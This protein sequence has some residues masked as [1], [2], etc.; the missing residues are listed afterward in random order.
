[1]GQREIGGITNL[2]R[3]VGRQEP[4]EKKRDDEGEKS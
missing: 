4:R 2:V 1:M 3:E